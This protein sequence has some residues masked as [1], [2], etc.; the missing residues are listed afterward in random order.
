MEQLQ[1]LLKDSPHY[2]IGITIIKEGQLEHHLIT[3]DFPLADMLKSHAKIKDL[4]VEQLE[5]N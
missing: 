5:K 4:I 1:E 2:M 3:S